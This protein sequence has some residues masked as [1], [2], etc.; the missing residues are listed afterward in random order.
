MEKFFVAIAVQG[1]DLDNMNGKK[2]IS[3]SGNKSGKYSTRLEAE[4]WAQ[5]MVADGNRCTY[6]V[7]EA[8]SFIKPKEMPFVTEECKYPLIG[9]EDVRREFSA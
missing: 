7:F 1:L 4:E 8:V 9:Y 2:G 5:K 6:V 3:F